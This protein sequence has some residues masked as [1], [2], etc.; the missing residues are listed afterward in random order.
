[1][2]LL[3]IE[4]IQV[5]Q[6]YDAD[7]PLYKMYKVRRS[8]RSIALSLLEKNRLFDKNLRNIRGSYASVMFAYSSGNLEHLLSTIPLRKFVSPRCYKLCRLLKS[9]NVPYRSRM[10]FYKSVM[11]IP[12]IKHY[13][14][15]KE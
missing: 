4:L 9:I 12:D 6:D 2:D 7:V 14:L 1:M 10:R 8:Q 13:N 11:L 15:L 5:I 3:P